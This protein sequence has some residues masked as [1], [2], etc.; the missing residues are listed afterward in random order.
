MQ[1]LQEELDLLHNQRDYLMKEHKDLWQMTAQEIDEVIKDLFKQQHQVEE[2]RHKYDTLIAETPDTDE[3]T[4]IR[5]QYQYNEG[6]F[7][8]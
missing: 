1:M 3:N 4:Q 6:D 2:I 5:S 7:F 8:I